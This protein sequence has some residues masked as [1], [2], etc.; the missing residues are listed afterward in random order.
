MLKQKIEENM[1][2]AQEEASQQMRVLEGQ[3]KQIEKLEANCKNFKERITESETNFEK[4]TKT[5][6]ELT[7]E[8]NVSNYDFYLNKTT[9]ILA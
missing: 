7:N 5:H 4:L 2:K 3:K 9:E 1:E 6:E 8:Y